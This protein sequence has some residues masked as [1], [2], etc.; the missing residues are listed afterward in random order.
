[1]PKTSAAGPD[2]VSARL[3][4]SIPAPVLVRIYN[5]IMWCEAL[6]EDFLRSRTVFVPKKKEAQ[7]PGDYR[8]ITIPPVLVRGLHKILARRM[9]RLLNIDV[10]Q[11][12]F[13]SSDGCSDNIFLLDT[14]LRIHRRKF[15]SLYMASLDVNKAIDSVSHPAIVAALTEIGVPEPMIRYLSSIYKRSTTVLEGSGWTSAP[16]HPRRGVRQGDPLSPIIF[17]A[18]THKMLRELSTDVGVRLGET[19][20]NAAA[21]ADDLLL[22]ATTTMGL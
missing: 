6:P 4:R 2:G 16:V 13:R 9:D 19:T 11:R 3:F 7:E 5:I 8:P 10:R 20:V 14:L 1:M 18:V 22:F 12:G 17:N 21:Y 15:R